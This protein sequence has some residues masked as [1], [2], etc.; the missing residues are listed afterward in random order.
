MRSDEKKRGRGVEGCVKDTD[1]GKSENQGSRRTDRCARSRLRERTPYTALAVYE[2]AI[3]RSNLG[4]LC[5]ITSPTRDI[6]PCAPCERVFKHSVFLFLFLLCFFTAPT[7]KR[8]FASHIPRDHAATSR[9]QGGGRGTSSFSARSYSLLIALLRISSAIQAAKCRN[10]SPSHARARNAILT[11]RK[12]LP[13]LF[14]FSSSFSFR[15]LV[16][17]ARFLPSVL[18]VRLPRAA[19]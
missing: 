18:H 9:G 11:R 1:A 14:V 5:T 8:E 10:S 3:N 6:R 2:K 15:L 13:F 19:C 12:L 4:D 17:L 7:R 16:I